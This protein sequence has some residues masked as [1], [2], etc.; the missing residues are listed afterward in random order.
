MAAHASEIE[1]RGL[2]DLVIAEDSPAFE[3]NRFTRHDGAFDPYRLRLFADGH[4]DEHVQVLGQVVLDDG[5]GLYVDGA[6]VIFTPW[7]E[8]DLR[9]MAGKLP[10]AIG[11]WGP[12]T[13]S[14][15]NP[16][17]GT[18]LM[19]QYH[20]T[21]L[22]YDVPPNA[23]ALLATAGA[24]QLNVDYHGFPE[25]IGMPIIDD[26]YWD[27]GVTLAGSQRPFEYALGVVAGAP[28]W[29]S[30]GKD[31][32]SGK[33]VLGRIGLAPIPALRLGVS[34]SYG[35]YLNR[36]VNASLPAGN[37][38]DQY[39]QKLVMA[40][41]EFQIAHFELHA[42]GVQNTWETP[43]VGDL[44]VDAGYA[45]LKV[46]TSSGMFVAGRYDVERFGKIEDSTGAEHPW[47]FDVDR[48]E[49][50]LGYRFTRDATAKLVYQRTVIENDRPGAE[51]R[52]L[53][54]VGAQLSIGF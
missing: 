5:A 42:E 46:A 23:D 36:R 7:P 52:E 22:W 30:T 39:A 8:R 26:S 28:G 47:D 1:W 43:T 20:T 34:A 41:L 12:R 13:Y 50:G 6:Y 15:K 11:T 24:G 14:N 25:G 3:G 9:L 38:V 19:Y 27:V 2:L 21:L 44:D 49:A 45:E 31:D 17:I 16:L 35:P 54:I 18:P 32:N 10:W 51:D 37:D 33:S 48:L 4:V 29:G 40:D 53:S